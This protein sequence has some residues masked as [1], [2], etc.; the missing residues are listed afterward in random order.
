MKAHCPELLEVVLQEIFQLPLLGQHNSQGIM[1]IVLEECR[2]YRIPGD[3]EE[4]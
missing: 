2:L 4:S 1:D 3:L